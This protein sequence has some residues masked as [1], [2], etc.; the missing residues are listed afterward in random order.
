MR[1]LFYQEE[2]Y[3]NYIYTGFLGLLFKWQHKLLSPKIYDNC[4]KVLEIGPGFEPHIKYK[5]LNFKEYHCLEL[6]DQQIEF[7]KYYSDNFTDVKFHYYDGK[8]INFDDN[9]FDRV[10]ISH[11]L[12]HT[13]NFENFIKEMTRVIKKEGVISIALPC[14]NGLLWR[15]GR[16]F[17]KKTY[18]KKKKI[19][20]IEYDYFIANEH[21]NTIFQIR[22]ILR[23]NF[24]IRSELYLPFRLKIIDINLFY[25]CHITKL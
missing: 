9:F 17:M 15:L 7:E 11:A 19:S 24:N 8:K 14:D 13:P 10:I 2:S 3:R 5:K 12:E 1:N 18:L 22:S 20:E 16:F 21:I 25:L 4:E 23:K 6:N